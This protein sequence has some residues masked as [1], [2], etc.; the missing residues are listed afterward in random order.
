LPSDEALESALARID[1]RAIRLHP[2]DKTVELLKPNMLLDLG[3]IAKGYALEQAYQVLRERGFDRV[4]LQAGGDI[5]LGD[6][7]PGKSGWR[8]GIGQTDPAKPPRMFLSLSNVEIATSGDR[9]QF[10]EIG[11]TR[12]SHL[13]DPKTGIGLIGH[14]QTTVVVPLGTLADGLSSSICIL[15]HEKGL[16]MLEKIPDAEAYIIAAPDSTGKEEIYQSTRWKNLP[17]CDRDEES[18][19]KP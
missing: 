9:F 13:I 12:Y 11:G 6:P 8:I 17:L 15:G 3:G 19:E 2:E 14:C 18:P 1:Y 5:L 4:L 16:R 10:V 7:P